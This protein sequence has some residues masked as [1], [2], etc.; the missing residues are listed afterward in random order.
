MNYKKEIVN[1]YEKNLYPYPL[2]KTKNMAEI[3]KKFLCLPLYISTTFKFFKRGD[4]MDIIFDGGHDTAEAAE[5]LMSVIRL[6]KERYNISHFREMHLTLT[7]VDDEGADV[8]LVDS[9][10]ME[11]Y[12]TFEVYRHGDELLKRRSQRRLKLVVDNT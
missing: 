5:Q 6:F 10:T 11:V 12:R 1:D 9:E 8:E 4:V 2:Y 3:F 7:L